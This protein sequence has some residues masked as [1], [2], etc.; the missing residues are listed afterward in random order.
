MEESSWIVYLGRMEGEFSL[1][2]RAEPGRKYRV[3]HSVPF[4]VPDGDLWIVS[5]P[6]YRLLSL[7][8][9]VP[10]VKRMKLGNPS[11]LWGW[12]GAF[13]EGL[14][15]SCPDP[16]RVVEIGTGKGT[17]LVRM[18]Y[19]LS[20][21]TDAKVWSVDLLECP[22]AQDCLEQ[23]QIPNWRYEFV[24]GDSVIVG[25][26]WTEALDFLYVDG[27]HNYAGC[28]ADIQVWSPFVKLHGVAAFHDYQ[29]PLHEV[30]QAVDEMMIA[31]QWENVGQVGT[32][33]AF[34]R[35]GY[36]PII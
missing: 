29:D 9:F 24:R 15:A 25:S 32:V 6:G 7:V 2:S 11:Y 3:Q 17:S 36:A 21:H 33:V 16:A 18:L 27:S 5:T 30:T 10:T 1:N 20:L 4:S 12:Q 35:V 28:K 13:I 14:A 22:D 8:D 26:K 19:G 34:E 23:A 31:G